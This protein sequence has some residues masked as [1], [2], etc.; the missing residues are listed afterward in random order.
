MINRDNIQQIYPLMQKQ[1]TLAY[2]SLQSLSNDPGLIQMR[3]L[4][5]GPLDHQAFSDAW[6]VLLERHEAMRASLQSPKNSLSMLVVLKHCLLPINWVDLRHKSRDE[7]QA[8]IKARFQDV[9]EQG[10]NLAHAPVHRLLGIRTGEEVVEFSWACHHLF[11]DGWS[12]VV[13]L[14]DLASLYSNIRSGV[15]LDPKPASTHADYLKWRSQCSAETAANYWSEQLAGYKQPVLF[16]SKFQKK[17]ASVVDVSEYHELVLLADPELGQT[18]DSLASDLKVT[19]GSI[20]YSV[21]AIFMGAVVDADDVIFGTTSAGRSFDLPDNQRM[22]GYYANVIPRRYRLENNTTLTNVLTKSHLKNFSALSFE[23]LSID[24]IQAE[25]GVLFNQSLFDNLVLFENLPQSD[26]VMRDPNGVVSIGTFSGDLTSSYP[27]TLTVRPD[28]KWRFKFLFSGQFNDE[29]LRQTLEL[30][31]AFLLATCNNPQESI[32]YHSNWIKA[33]LPDFAN[34]HQQNGVFKVPSN[35]SMQLAR[36][37]TEFAISEVWQ[38]VLG[39]TEIDIHTEFI[40]LGGRSVAAVRMLAEIEDRFGKPVA[41]VDFVHKPTVAAIARLIDGEHTS[42]QW[43]CLIPLKTTGSR[44]P[45]VFVHAVG[46]HAL[47]MRSITSYF[48]DDQPVFGL[49]LVGLDGECEP[50]RSIKTIASLYIAELKTVQ[51]EGPYYFVSH[52]LGAVVAHEMVTQLKEQGEDIALFVVLDAIPPLVSKKPLKRKKY[53]SI[54]RQSFEAASVDA[55]W[56]LSKL[57]AKHCLYRAN[58]KLIKVRQWYALRYG[59]TLGRKE[60]YMQLVHS[61]VYAGYDDYI[62]RPI[63]QPMVFVCC[64]TELNP[65]FSGWDYLASDF[66]VLNLP[67][68][69]DT[70]FTEP[71]VGILGQKLNQLL[72]EAKA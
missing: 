2:Y 5:K 62:G 30:F 20:L 59:S 69:H 42:N 37:K 64:E 10:L 28:K 26:I 52:C 3:F 23:Y 67:V 53:N 63:D 43:R 66:K 60:A 39:L 41:M 32:A 54:V 50:L 57:V 4:I 22:V 34:S 55:F 45:I 24:E 65:K 19:S 12:A 40:A 17:D 38:S 21:W 72:H 68:G 25:T 56:G 7:Q 14:N 70:M 51:P 49:Q 6:Q 61:A 11:L 13:L 18:I 8:E 44:A 58:S 48:D 29:N 47:F 27:L 71:E 31:P 46:T 9:R 36:S 35:T 15:A 1:R 16:G 33:K